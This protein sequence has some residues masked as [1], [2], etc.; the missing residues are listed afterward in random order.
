MSFCTLYKA[1]FDRVK[2]NLE[3]AK[4]ILAEAEITAEKRIKRKFA[5]TKPRPAL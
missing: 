5:H 1:A 4:I 2:A 3:A